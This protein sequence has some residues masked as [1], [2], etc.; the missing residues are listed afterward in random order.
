MVSMATAVKKL[1]VVG[2]AAKNAIA[3]IISIR[4]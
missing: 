2:H 1:D 4:G 3:D